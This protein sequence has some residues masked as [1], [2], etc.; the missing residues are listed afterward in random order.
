M[1]SILLL[2]F[3]LSLSS[4]VV[5]KDIALKGAFPSVS[6]AANSTNA[7][8][9]ACA[10][11][12]HM[13]VA[14]ASTEQPGQGIIGAVA[15]QVQQQ[16]PGSDSEAVDY[17]AT[18]TDYLNSEASGVA[19]MTKLI[20][21][22]AARCPNSK[23][24]LLGYSQVLVTRKTEEELTNNMFREL[25][26][27]VILCVGRVRLIS[28]RPNPF[29]QHCRRIVSLIIHS[30]PSLLALPGIS[31]LLSYLSAG[32]LIDRETRSHQ[33]MSYET[34]R[35]GPRTILRSQKYSSDWLNF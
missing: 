32:S 13:I 34:R 17:P 26:S 19:A 10:T 3:G 18:L 4:A 31:A 16:V 2:G 27:L 24:A 20:E 21:N 22:Y 35:L 15:T 33:K 1:K 23:M 5:L 11:G 28:I 6:H 14:R 8:T 12:V 9:T 30:Q 25:K 7:N 29:P